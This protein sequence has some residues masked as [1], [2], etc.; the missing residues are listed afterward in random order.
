MDVLVKFCMVGMKSDIE[1]R[2]NYLEK[3]MTDFTNSGD[4]LEII[5][6]EIEDPFGNKCQHKFSSTI[7]D[8]FDYKIIHQ[9]KEKAVYFDII[10]SF[11]TY[12]NSERLSI[13][14]SS[15]DYIVEDKGQKSYLERLKQILSKKL[16]ADW[17]KCIWLYDQESEFF[18]TALYPMVHRTENKM[19]HFINEVMVVIKGFDWWNELV[20]K[21][22]KVKLDKSKDLEGNSDSKI[23]EYKALVSGFK[24]VDEKLMLIDVGDLISIITLREKKLTTIN[25]NILNA[26]ISGHEEF[27]IQKLRTE[28]GKAAEVELDLWDKCF[29]KYLS[30][31]FVRNFRKFEKNRNHIAHNKLIDR[32]AFESIRDSIKVVSV[33]LEAAMNK[34]ISDNLPQEIISIIEEAEAEEEEAYNDILDE[35]IESQ[36]GLHRRKREEILDLF[37]DNILNLYNFLEENFSFRADI[38]F[39]NFSGIVDHED[40]QELFRV[41]YKIT[42]DELI[43]YC[44]QDINDNWGEYSYINLKWRHGKHIVEYEINYTNPDYEQDSEEE[45]YMPYF[46]EEF[47]QKKF[48]CATNE[49]LE[50]IEI[51]F[52]NMREIVDAAMYRIIKDGG[53]NPLAEIP[54]SECGEEYICVDETIAEKGLCLNCGNMHDLCECERCG[55]YYEGCDSDYEDDEPRIC[56]YCLDHYKNE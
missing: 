40:E 21:N 3:I 23:S 4:I 53:N 37:E 2:E 42:N 32:Q 14:I 5:H 48:E 45:L 27:D 39:S 29:S 55:K 24:H 54:C 56:D 28:L 51:N 49:I 31:D 52:E 7:D 44:E 30:E 19:R 38:E 17:K 15:D 22:I 36:T 26:F 33:E 41:V 43:V 47:E 46:D 9:E 10:F 16:F 6:F 20:P 12:D 13:E 18:A 11:E 35:L 25:S 50:Y 34:F 8:C 1:D